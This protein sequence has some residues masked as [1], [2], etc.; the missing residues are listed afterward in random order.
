LKVQGPPWL[1]DL[2]AMAARNVTLTV[3]R[4]DNFRCQDCG[5]TGTPDNPI[6]VHHK[7]PRRWDASRIMDPENE[8]TLC[9]KCHDKRENRVR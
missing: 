1:E 7:V 6:T 2:K 8:V 4:R 9:R 5:C 3:R